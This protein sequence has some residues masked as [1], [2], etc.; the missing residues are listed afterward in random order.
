MFHIDKYG[1]N[2]GKKGENGTVYWYKK[3]S[4]SHCTIFKKQISEQII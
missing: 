2:R 3:V 1:L 4:K